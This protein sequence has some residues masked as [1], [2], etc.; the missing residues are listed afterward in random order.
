M[1]AC[2]CGRLIH[3]IQQLIK[4]FKK[5]APITFEI[6]YSSSADHSL[7]AAVIYFTQE[8]LHKQL[9]FTAYGLFPLDY[10]FF[11]SIFAT[12]LTYSIII[13]QSSVP[14]RPNLTRFTNE[15]N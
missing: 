11:Q 3:E 1:A 6:L 2:L 7:K 4:E 8:L 12:S 10:T 5:T 13:L 14:S 9:T 15:T